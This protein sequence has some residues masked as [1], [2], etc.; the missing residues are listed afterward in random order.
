VAPF[1]SPV[2]NL[3]NFLA[4]IYQMAKWPH[5][6]KFPAKTSFFLKSN[7]WNFTVFLGSVFP[8]VCLLATVLTIPYKVSAVKAKSV[9]I[10]MGML[11]S[12]TTVQNKK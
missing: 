10:C 4:K 11:A 6:L 5:C 3:F 2:I 7:L 9:W 8:H 12:G 1:L